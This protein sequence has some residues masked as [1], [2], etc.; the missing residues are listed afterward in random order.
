MSERGCALSL[1]P[2]IMTEI[3]SDCVKAYLNNNVSGEWAT[4]VKSLVD[5]LFDEV[6][7]SVNE[8]KHKEE[9][10]Q[11]LTIAKIMEENL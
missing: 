1:T 2:E 8:H 6:A 11:I 7:K 4:A 10:T 9:I 5:S 3:H